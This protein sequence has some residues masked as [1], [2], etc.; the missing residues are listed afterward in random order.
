[1]VLS[2][3]TT[4]P[5]E[6]GCLYDLTV[7]GEVCAPCALVEPADIVAGTDPG[8]CGAV[9]NYP[10]PT[11]TGACTGVITCDPPSGSFFAPGTT[12]VTCTETGGASTTFDITVNDTEAPTITCPADIEQDLPPGEVEGVVTWADLVVGD[13]CP[14]GPAVCVPP[15]GS[16]FPGGETTAVN[17]AVTDGAGASAT[18]AFN[19]T[20]G[21]VSILEIPTLSPAGIGA[22]LLAFAGAGFFLLRRRR[23]AR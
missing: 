16:I 22:L 2:V 5:G 1:M 13:N 6:I 11:T 23:A 14:V 7:V 21:I 9:V 10:P 4:N 17:C 3:H 18:C 20:L 15:S 8:A 12:T 19:V